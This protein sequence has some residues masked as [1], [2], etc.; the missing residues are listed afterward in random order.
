MAMAA[1]TALV[2]SGC[3]NRGDWAG[4]WTGTRPAP[5]SPGT[6]PLITKSLA[7]VTLVIKKDGHFELTEETF[8]KSGAAVLGSD[9]GTLVIDTVLGRRPASLGPSGQ[10]MAGER[11]VKLQKDGTMLLLRPDYEP[12]ALKRTDQGP[13]KD[14]TG[15]Q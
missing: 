13:Q 11:S 15:A 7:T 5:D 9:T 4:E 14:G 1:L 6:D 12:V 3:A 8:G 2:L 10:K